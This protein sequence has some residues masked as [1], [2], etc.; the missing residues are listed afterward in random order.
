MLRVC[1]CVQGHN[2]EKI[3]RLNKQ[4]LEQIRFNGE[5]L[6]TGQ[7]LL[8]DLTRIITS[9]A[10]FVSGDFDLPLFC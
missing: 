1:L 6:S 5:P 3:H 4:E 8:H 9:A 2:P 10:W 7:F